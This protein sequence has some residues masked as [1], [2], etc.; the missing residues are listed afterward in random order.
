MTRLVPALLFSAIF[1]SSAWASAN[2]LQFNV[3]LCSKSSASDLV[4][5][6][7]PVSDKEL[8]VRFDRGAVKPMLTASDKRQFFRHSIQLGDD[9]ISIGA[10]KP[11]PIEALTVINVSLSQN[12]RGQIDYNEVSFFDDKGKNYASFSLRPHTRGAFYRIKL[13]QKTTLAQ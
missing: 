8:F 4:H 12:G 5:K 1:C 2:R 11:D 10:W 7:K 6:C 13:N 3:E 9:E